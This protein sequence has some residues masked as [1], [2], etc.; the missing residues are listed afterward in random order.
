LIIKQSLWLPQNVVEKIHYATFVHVQLTTFINVAMLFFQRFHIN[1]ADLL[2][3]IPNLK[4]SQ[5][6]LKIHFPEWQSPL[7]TPQIAVPTWKFMCHLNHNKYL[8]I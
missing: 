4:K 5:Y 2:I 8:V 1:A 7:H 6:L 3:S